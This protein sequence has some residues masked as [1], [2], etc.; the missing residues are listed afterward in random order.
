MRFMGDLFK[1]IIFVFSFF[2]RY[3]KFL[4]LAIPF[5]FIFSSSRGVLALLTKEGVDRGLVQGNVSD[6]TK[7]VIYIVVLFFVASISRIL[8]SYLV[9]YSVQGVIRDIREK[10]FSNIISVSLDKN[11]SSSSTVSRLLGDVEIISGF[12][13]LLKTIL[14]EPFSLFFLSGV[15]IYINWK[16]ALF[17]LLAF[18]LVALPAGYI[19]KKVRKASS[20]TRKSAESISQKIIESIQGAKVVRIYSIDIIASVFK[21]HLDIF[22][23]YSIKS[24]ILPEFA[25]SIADISGALIIGAVV[26]F[27]AIEI[28]SG[29]MTVGSFFAFVGATIGLWEP[30]KNLIRVPSEIG[31][32][33][34]SAERI[35]E[36]QKIQIMVGGVIRKE[37]FDDSIS[38]RG[39]SVRFGDKLVLDNIN[40]EI[41]KFQKVS[42][43]GR[44]GVGKTT[45]ISLL[46]RFFDPSEGSITIDSI[47]LNQID[48]QSLRKLIGFVEQEPFIFDDTIY[49]NVRIA[50]PDSKRSEIEKAMEDAG[51]DLKE[52]DLNK[53]C[54]E[55]G[56]NLSLGQRQRIAIA[57]AFL[58]NSPIII[59]DEPTSSIDPEL[60]DALLKTFEKLMEGK[61]VLIVSHKP[62]TALFAQRYI[63]IEGGKVY[64][65]DRDMMMNFFF[66]SV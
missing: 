40:L 39:V 37:T 23:K 18:S 61:T 47:E 7:V 10:V 17:S 12:P 38:F 42:I 29:N 58:K 2:R 6:I 36:F 34:P 64:E 51:F 16:L 62:K 26:I 21:K 4:I 50:K 13:D 45:L 66:S 65:V 15:L 27:S 53:R 28:S 55:N 1:D 43:I 31:R 5:S 54:G 8:S 44:S 46:P 59:M 14:K 56:K 48:I 41:K 3:T 60:E 33:I 25:S 9:N 19:G 11:I 22:R 20:R 57:R 35:D 30:I 32:I 49:E 63:M 24:K 52:I